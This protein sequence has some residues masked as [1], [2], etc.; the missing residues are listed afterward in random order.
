MS[1]FFLISSLLAAALVAPALH[2]EESKPA[3][4]PVGPYKVKNRSS[5]S[6]AAAVRPPF[7]PVGWVK[8]DKAV[9]A[10]VA[11][12][13]FQLTPEAFSLTSILVG[14]P[15][16]AVINNRAYAEGEV[17]RGAKGGQNDPHV[18]VRVQR[19]LDGRVVLQSGDGQTV[20]VGIRRPELTERKVQEEL[21]IREE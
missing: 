4:A 19:I 2:A 10:E 14:N 11:A 16:L 5:F 12:P 7:W 1:R 21:L 3:E 20:T 6:P 15:S 18:R 17:V 13:R 9:A 8:R